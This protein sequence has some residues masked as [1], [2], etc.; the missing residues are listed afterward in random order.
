MLKEKKLDDNRDMIDR[1]Q[2]K[3]NKRDDQY[4]PWE[5]R[6][7]Y[8][9]IMDGLEMQRTQLEI[10]YENSLQKYENLNSPPNSNDL[11]LAEAD[12]LD[13]RARLA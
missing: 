7:R 10:D 11:T 8:R 4:K 1:I 3:L 9:Q 12:L 5:S 13:A 6:R 2:K